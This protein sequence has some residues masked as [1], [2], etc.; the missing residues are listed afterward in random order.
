MVGNGGS[1]RQV[2]T[3]SPF[4]HPSLDCLRNSQCFFDTTVLAVS[5]EREQK[6]HKELQ[7]YLLSEKQHWQKGT[8]ADKMKY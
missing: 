5:H 3:Q 7:R 8:F 4:Q 2:G 1:W 6:Q